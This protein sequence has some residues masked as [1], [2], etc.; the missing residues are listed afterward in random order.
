VRRA[1]WAL[2]AVV[3]LLLPAG[4]GR[5]AG[6]E[7]REDRLRPLE[8]RLDRQRARI[9]ATLRVVRRRSARDA[10]ALREDVDALAALV[11]EIAALAPPDEARGEF[12]GYVVALRALVGELR[13]F[14]PALRRGE[15]PLLDAAS[16]RIQEA[17][18]GVQQRKEHLERRL[19]GL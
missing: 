11:R 8:Q 4:C 3:L 17:T 19:L 15:E 1:R 12:D 13:A 18:G 10:R 5:S 14:G 6:E 9:A 16:L 7:F 2:G